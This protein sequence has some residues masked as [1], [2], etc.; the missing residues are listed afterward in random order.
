V[1]LLPVLA[2]RL[3]GF[4]AFPA[5]LLFYSYLLTFAL[6]YYIMVGDMKNSL[7]VHLRGYRA[8]A[9]AAP[10]FKF[11]EAAP[12]LI[13]PMV[14]ASILDNGVVTGD[15]A[16]VTRGV[17]LL[18]ALGGFGM[19]SA[20][21][22]QYFAAV[23]ATGFGSNL[24]RALFTRITRLSAE[25]VDT[26]GTPELVT[27]L[28]TDTNIVQ[29]AVNAS[30]RLLLR[31]P[32][33]VAGALVMAFIMDASLAM[34]FVVLVP[35]L[36][37]VT[38]MF[39]LATA[40]MYARIQQRLERV[41]SRV[42]DNL[43]GARVLRSLAR[44]NAE[45]DEFTDI[46]NSLTSSQRRAAAI[47]EIMTPLTF[48]MVNI[49]LIMLVHIGAIGVGD[50]RTSTGTIIAMTTYTALILME[51]TKL[52]RLLILINRAIVSARRIKEVMSVPQPNLTRPGLSSHGVDGEDGADDTAVF[53]KDLSMAYHGGSDV[54]DRTSFSINQGQF[55]CITGA[56][57]CGKSSLLNTIAG[58]Y[59]PS[60]GELCLLGVDM[61]RADTAEIDTVRRR[62]ALVPQKPRLLSGSLRENLLWGCE[63]ATD[64]DLLHSV[65]LAQA[66]D[67]L[68]SLGGLDGMVEQGGV[69][70]SGGQRQRLAIA[71]ALVRRPEIL[72]LDDPTSALDHDTEEA[73]I[74]A[75]HSL[76]TDTTVIM[77]T[78]NRTAIDLADAVVKMG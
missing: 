35:V 74:A 76:R 68:A 10:I 37:A 52:V 38:I 1:E 40:P 49:A 32:I 9:V 61:T 60:S 18:F 2:K 13:V 59:R 30:L 71:R 19:A 46:H 26:I 50:G 14:V 47:A 39:M 34:I 45:F 65:E 64:T 72:L 48:L 4:P 73:V 36:F 41:V 33:M 57:G 3:F 25:Q 11:L 31:S 43:S 28:T 56:T 70:L 58:Q 55:V 29:Q 51:Q 44:E 20:V 8:T 15:T 53:A 6:K 75:L 62:I 63:K 69:N 5:F 54:F 77:V 7:F 23:A 24:R 42:D 78:H 27:R 17:L 66:G 22:G 16:Y 67:A 12:E 21:G